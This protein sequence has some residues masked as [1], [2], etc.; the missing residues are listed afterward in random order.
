MSVCSQLHNF[1]GGLSV[2]TSAC[3]LVEGGF[4]V[5]GSYSIRAVHRTTTFLYR[6]HILTHQNHC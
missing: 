4:V 5:F 2:S 1:A 3:S 6:Q